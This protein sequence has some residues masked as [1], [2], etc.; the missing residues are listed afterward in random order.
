[1]PTFTVIVKDNDSNIERTVTVNTATME[2]TIVD[3]TANSTVS[4]PES[5]ITHEAQSVDETI[6]VEQPVVVSEP[7]AQSVPVPEPVAE[8]NNGEYAGVSN[9]FKNKNGG[10]RSASSFRLK[11]RR[12]TRKLRKVR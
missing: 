2:A 6:S 9:L 3:P 12:I 1:M 8:P 7:D 10:K 5:G 11:K 4:V